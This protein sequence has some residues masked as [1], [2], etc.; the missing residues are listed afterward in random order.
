MDENQVKSSKTDLLERLSSG[1]G[2]Q[3]LSD[4]R[5]MA[6]TAQCRLI[7]AEIPA[8]EYSVKTWSDAIYYITGEKTVYST[9]QEARMK[10]IGWLENKNKK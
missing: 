8:E 10:L 9:P 3:Y 4:L 1:M 2:C 7:L 6:H 5:G